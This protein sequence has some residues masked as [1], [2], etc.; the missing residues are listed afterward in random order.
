MK[1]T[2]TKS[3]IEDKLYEKNPIYEL[4]Y[5]IVEIKP[6]KRINYRFCNKFTKSKTQKRIYIERLCIAP[7][8]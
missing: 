5:C 8:H 4:C 7:L 1:Y 2:N 3:I 6:R